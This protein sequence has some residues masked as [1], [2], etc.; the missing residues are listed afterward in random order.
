MGS[1]T[2]RTFFKSDYP[3]RVEDALEQSFAED[4]NW[5]VVCKQVDERDHRSCR[6]CGRRT[7]PD[8]VGLLRGHRHHIVYRSAGGPDSTD[9]LCTLCPVCHSDEH[10]KRTLEIEGNADDALAFWRKDEHDDWYLWRR[11]IS[12]GRFEHD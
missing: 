1:V 11:E 5:R 2:H 7:N 9:N 4:A 10:V 12:V 8:H 6:A 3:S